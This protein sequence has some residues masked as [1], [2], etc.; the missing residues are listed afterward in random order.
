MRKTQSSTVWLPFNIVFVI[1]FK[2]I[3][4]QNT[5]T[6]KEIKFISLATFTI[7]IRLL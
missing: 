7:L 4:A 1:I 5:F 2:F 6:T 3:K